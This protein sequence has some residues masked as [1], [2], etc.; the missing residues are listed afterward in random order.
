M[1]L[2]TDIQF[3]IDIK[4]PKQIHPYFTQ[5]PAL[6]TLFSSSDSKFFNENIVWNFL[7]S[8]WHVCENQREML[9]QHHIIRPI[10]IRNQ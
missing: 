1:H 7:D 9:L 8:C 6:I 2:S 10:S 4:Y 3:C 5:D